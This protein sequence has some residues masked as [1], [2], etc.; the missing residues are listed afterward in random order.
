MIAVVLLRSGILVLAHK[1]KITR[2]SNDEFYKTLGWS[3]GKKKSPFK[4]PSYK[5]H[6]DIATSDEVP[7]NGSKKE[8]SKYTGDELLGIATMHKSNPVPIR[9][10]SKDAAKDVARM[11]RN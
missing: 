8:A 9:K 10:D 7:A 3:P 11:R 6:S 5:C 1:K 4:I 2:E